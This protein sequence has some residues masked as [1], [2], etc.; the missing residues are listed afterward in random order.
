MKTRLGQNAANRKL[1]LQKIR[2][3][4]DTIERLRSTFKANLV[5]D[6][7]EQR[8]SSGS[9]DNMRRMYTTLNTKKDLFLGFVE[10]VREALPVDTKQDKIVAAARQLATDC[11]ERMGIFLAR[12]RGKPKTVRFSPYLYTFAYNLFERSKSGFRQAIKDG[13][14]LPSERQMYRIKAGAAVTSGHC[15]K[16]FQKIVEETGGKAIIGQIL[17]DEMKIVGGVVMNSQ[18]YDIVGFEVDSGDFSQMMGTLGEKR[19]HKPASYVMQYMFRDMFSSNKIYLLENFAVSKGCNHTQIKSQLLRQILLCETL[20]LR[21]VGLMKDGAGANLKTDRDLLGMVSR[22]LY[23]WF[24]KKDVAFPNP[25]DDE[26]DIA[27][28]ACGSH[29]VKNDRGALYSP[30]R[31]LK[32][33][34]NDITWKVL[35]ACWRREEDRRLKGLLQETRLVV[36]AVLNLDGFTKMRVDYAKI[37]F[38]CRTIIEIMLYMCTVLHVEMPTGLTLEEKVDFLES[39]LATKPWPYPADSADPNPMGT[40][41][42]MVHMN[43]LYHRLVLNMANKVTE[44]NI[45]VLE[46]KCKAIFEGYFHEWKESIASATEFLHSTTWF[47]LRGSFK[48]YFEMCR[49]AFKE[50]RV[51]HSDLNDPE[52]AMPYITMNKFNQS[53]LELIFCIVR[54][55][56]MGSVDLTQYLSK[57]SNVSSIYARKTDIGS[58]S[59]DELRRSGMYDPNDVDGGGVDGEKMDSSPA[60]PASAF[61]ASAASSAASSE[62]AA[63]AADD[64]Q[65]CSRAPKSI[66]V[67]NRETKATLDPYRKLL[68]AL[69]ADEAQMH[70]LSIPGIVSF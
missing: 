18:S 17:F 56:S 53:C 68:N 8:I 46:E 39:V 45:D 54:T 3:L 15:I 62:A 65:S 47:I 44:E 64:S 5:D 40:V 33:D 4:E 59:S 6:E 42:F 41:K 25:Y 69:L 34:G 66:D 51:V 32:F 38:E 60:P 16:F 49:I 12:A 14:T 63:V 29:N 24:E 9:L 67:Y 36:D 43:A 19:I 20:N 21:V 30:K 31:K 35:E 50:Y 52:Y 13:Q 57:V 26:R 22:P 37:A 58:S 2:R 11:Q 1:N 48:G 27:T 7:V 55:G 23:S 10:Q 61:A 70:R 28:A